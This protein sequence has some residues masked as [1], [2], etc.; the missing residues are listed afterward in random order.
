MAFGSGAHSQ[1]VWVAVGLRR[2][3]VVIKA[4]STPCRRALS[5]WKQWD[6]GLRWWCSSGP[7]LRGLWIGIV[8]LI[9]ANYSCDSGGSGHGDLLRDS[10][11]R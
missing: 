8:M 5:V 3:L 10:V 6:S 9:P 4:G 7:V 11:A 1:S 2:A